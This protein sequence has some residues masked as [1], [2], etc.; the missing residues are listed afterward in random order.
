MGKGLGDLVRG[1]ESASQILEIGPHRQ[2]ALPGGRLADEVGGEQAQ[3]RVGAEPGML[4]PGARPG[5]ER[6]EPLLVSS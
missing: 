5:A 6:V 2:Q 1:V 3:D 4:W